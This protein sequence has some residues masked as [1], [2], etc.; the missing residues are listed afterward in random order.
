MI[1]LLQLI[2]ST[3][4]I[5]PAFFLFNLV[6]PSCSSSPSIFY[7]ILTSI[8][9]SVSAAP[10]AA[11]ATI[12]FLCFFFHVYFLINDTDLFIQQLGTMS[13]VDERK[14]A[15]FPNHSSTNIARNLQIRKHRA[16]RFFIFDF[17]LCSVLFCERMS[18]EDEFFSDLTYFFLSQS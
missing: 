5:I 9:I 16:P 15:A 12:D 18:E 17:L 11:V 3:Q 8:I 7:F 10:A 13:L 6:A 1:K 2:F 14:L 4:W